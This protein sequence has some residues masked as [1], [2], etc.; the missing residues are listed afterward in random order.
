MGMHQVVNSKG[1]VL[2]EIPF[3]EAGFAPDAVNGS[4]CACCAEARRYRAVVDAVLQRHQR[5][6]YGHPRCIVCSGAEGW[7]CRE[8]QAIQTALEERE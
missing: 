4:D 8:V 2:H 6:V 1:E 5:V 7:P 3:P